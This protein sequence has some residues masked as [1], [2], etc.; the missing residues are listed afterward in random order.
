MKTYICSDLHFEF[1]KD[2]G[3][4]FIKSNYNDA[5]TIIVA[6]DLSCSD[7]LILSLGIL[8]TK[9]KTVIYVSGN[10]C[11]YGSSSSDM[12]ETRFKALKT[13]PNLHWLDK[14]VVEID[15]VKFAGCT[16]WFEKDRLS[17]IFKM[18]LSDFHVIRGFDPWV[19]SENKRC[20]DFLDKNVDKDTIVI[21]H[22]LP[23]YQSVS[24]RFIG[25]DINRYFVS[26]L[27]EMII[28]EKS[29]RL[30]VHGH[31]HDSKDYML[32]NTRVYCNPLGYI[33][34]EINKT[35]NADVMGL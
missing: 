15:G 16:L 10:H 2:G 20:L 25:S 30:W 5:D 24:R 22:H 11:Y 29:P 21:T 32:E 17:D 1:H 23:S 13:Y 28:R 12:N 18:G 6:G 14:E 31:T 8:C 4:D 35:F 33:D 9:F 26:P 27:A 19:Y 7:T 34:L 3:L